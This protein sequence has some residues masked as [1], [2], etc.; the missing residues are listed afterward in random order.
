MRAQPHLLRGLNRYWIRFFILAVY[1]TMYVRDHTR[2]LLH[3][4]MG[5]N[6]ETYDYDVFRITSEI[7]RQVFPIEVD[8][9]HPV[10]R[11]CLAR[12][13]DIS[14]QAAKAKERGGLVGKLMHGVCAVQAAWTFA[15][16]YFVPVK[17]NALP[18]QVRLQPTW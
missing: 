15:R 4:A 9:D 18:E 1:A 2:P 10:F 14:I 17:T 11:A 6:S 13:L 7:S 16:L 8:I 12:L 5:L 3:Q